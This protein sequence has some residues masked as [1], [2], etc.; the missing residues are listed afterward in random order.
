[1]FN[2]QTYLKTAR[3][4][5]KNAG[6]GASIKDCEDRGGI[7]TFVLSSNIRDKDKGYLQK[8]LSK[9]FNQQVNIQTVNP[10]QKA[11]QIGG[12]GPCGMPLCCKRWLSQP[13]EPQK[14]NV[15]NEQIMFSTGTSE[16]ACSQL[17]CCLCYAKGA[18]Y[19]AKSESEQI[20]SGKKESKQ[21][22]EENLQ[23]SNQKEITKKQNKPAT[24]KIRRLKI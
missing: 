10:R 18:S 13:L 6:V 14:E 24:K 21:K 1:M 8:E 16:G 20:N 3:N 11:A 7:L 9:T 5:A 19:C 4:A 23:N 12:I 22:S 2:K 17:L 15:K